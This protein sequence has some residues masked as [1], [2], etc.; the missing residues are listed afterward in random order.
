MP[1]ILK[2]EVSS[3]LKTGIQTNACKGTFR[4][5]LFRRVKRY[6]QPKYPSTDEWMNNIQ[7]INIVEYYSAIKKE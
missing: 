1:T 5:A 2:K 7:C 6:K 3:E 4:A